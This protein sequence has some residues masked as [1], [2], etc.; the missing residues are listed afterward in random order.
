MESPAIL[1]HTDDWIA[2]QKPAFWL[3]VASSRPS[4]DRPIL[5]AWIR[6][7][8]GPQT[9][10]VHRLDFETSG[11]ILFARS[12]ESER[13]LNRAFERRQVRKRYLFLAFGTP[14]A[15]MF[16]ARSTIE[17]KPAQT[18]FQIVD[19][20]A[21]A[22]AFF[23]EAHPVSGRRHQ[24]RIHLKECGTPI[25]GDVEY[26][27]PRAIALGGQSLSI[28][29][30]LL[31]AASIEIPGIASV[32]RSIKVDCPLPADFTKVLEHLLPGARAGTF[33]GTS[34]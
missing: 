4:E 21:G 26:G 27:G 16:Q 23:G 30:V 20:R 17:G 10:C 31:H 11:V 12:R 15:P 18:R 8:L 2:V 7:K 29:R 19:A 22:P 32:G 1:A 14:K 25:L 3:S 13:A 6:D 9:Y 33:G 28:P 34:Q 5:A 24:I